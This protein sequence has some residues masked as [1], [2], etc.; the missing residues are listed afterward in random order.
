[1]SRM[2]TFEGI[3]KAVFFPFQGTNRGMKWLIGSAL[4]LASFIIPIVPLIPLYGYG[5]Q[6]AKR[7]LIQDEDPELPEWKD[8]GLLFSDG[9]KLLGAAILYTLP[10]FILFFGGYLMFFLI[11]M[12][13]IPL[14]QIGT[15]PGSISP[16]LFG[17]T[18][19]AFLG[20][21]GM[22][23]GMLVFIAG[24]FFLPP[25][26]SHL[27]TKN[28][29]KAAFAVKEWWPIFKNNLGGFLLALILL[30]GVNFSLMWI[31]YL[32]YF[33]IVLCFVMPLAML[34]IIYLTTVIQFSLF[35]IPY[36]DSI[37]KSNRE[38]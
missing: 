15:E 9:I 25:A 10:G 18:A 23:L 19:A 28:E 3:K 32:F 33:T 30:V 36:R 2:A 35:A 27:I 26:L 24:L 29:F 12:A 34:V 14:A 17:S 7:I 31:A 16:V 11:N 37:E 8:W 5:A 6:I 4:S 13:V 1:M 20:I 22:F 21:A 38:T